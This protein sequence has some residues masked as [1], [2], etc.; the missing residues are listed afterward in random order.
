MSSPGEIISEHTA[1][2]A[3]AMAN[4]VRVHILELLVQRERSVDEI[5]LALD[6]PLTSVSSQLK[7]LREE[8]LVET[9]RD[10]VR[11]HYRIADESVVAALLALRGVAEA[12]NSVVQQVVRDFLND[13]SSLAHVDAKSLSRM[14]QDGDAVLIDVRPRDEYEAGHIPGALS[15]PLDELDAGRIAAPEDARVLAYCRDAYC[16]LAPEAV[17]RLRRHGMQVVR[18]DFGFSE[19]AAG[20]NTIAAAASGADEAVG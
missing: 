15:M 2:V 3:H 7:V 13:D 19:W 9:R 6:M 16:V 17:R 18:L 10:G 5:R 14:M 4:P 8:R 11:I 12:R 1:R 20:G